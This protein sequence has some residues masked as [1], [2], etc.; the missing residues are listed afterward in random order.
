MQW[1]REVATWIKTANQLSGNLS[2]AQAMHTLGKR[3]DDADSTAALVGRIQEM[4]TQLEVTTALICERTN[5]PTVEAAEELLQ[6]LE[7]RLKLHAEEEDQLRR[8][9]AQFEMAVA[10]KEF[11]TPEERVAGEDILTELQARVATQF[12]L[13]EA[14]VPNKAVLL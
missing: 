3:L 11:E 2:Q 6:D 7:V 8:A 14:L 10:A 13:A 4:T 1:Y 9:R 12:G 5:R